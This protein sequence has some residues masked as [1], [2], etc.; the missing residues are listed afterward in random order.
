MGRISPHQSA[1]GESLQFDWIKSRTLSTSFAISL[2]FCAVH[3]Y[4]GLC[5]LND[6]PG[7]SCYEW[8]AEE[9][10]VIELG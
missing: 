6:S 7:E 1:T 2:A 3:E 9:S 4:M 5:D 10:S 8:P